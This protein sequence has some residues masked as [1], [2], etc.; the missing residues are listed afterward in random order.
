[1]SWKSATKASR[2]IPC[3]PYLI[4]LTLTIDIVTI[5][6]FGSA[7]SPLCVNMALFIV[8]GAISLVTVNVYTKGSVYTNGCYIAH[9]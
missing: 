8:T 2:G 5:L 9:R 1:M 7:L 4:M 6:L 3:D